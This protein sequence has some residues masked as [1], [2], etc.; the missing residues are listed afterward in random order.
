MYCYL[1]LRENL[2]K[3][4][5]IGLLIEIILIFKALCEFH[6]PNLIK[7]LKSNRFKPRSKV[8]FSSVSAERLK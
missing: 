5:I 7:S 4:N 3:W 8:E 2:L 1:I 6:K